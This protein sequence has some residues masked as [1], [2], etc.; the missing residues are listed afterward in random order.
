MDIYFIKVSGVPSERVHAGL[1][2]YHWEEPETYTLFL[3]VQG[4]LTDSN[5]KRANINNVVLAEQFYDYWEPR[6]RGRKYGNI[7]IEL[8]SE[9]ANKW[10]EKTVDKTSERITELLENGAGKNNPSKS[11]KY[12]GKLIIKL[13]FKESDG[14]PAAGFLSAYRNDGI[15]SISSHISGA[16]RYKSL[17]HCRKL[18]SELE[19]HVNLEAEIKSLSD[20]DVGIIEGH[21]EERWD[22]V[23]GRS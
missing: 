18:I 9:T 23:F 14:A 3:T 1:R 8:A 16:R 17:P 20:K 22:F 6:L 10:Q 11:Q 2:K 7:I 21:K 15:V 19:S 4:R 13:N 5:T 12:D